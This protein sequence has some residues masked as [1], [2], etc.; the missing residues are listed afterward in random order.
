MSRLLKTLSL[1]L[2]A[3]TLGLTAQAGQFMVEYGKTKPLRLAGEAGSIVVGNPEIADVAVHDK[4][5]LFITG[6]TYGT[7]NLMVFDQHGKSVYVADVVVTTNGSNL[8]TVNRAGIDFT[9][10]CAPNCRLEGTGN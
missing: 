8:V 9:Y 5:L 3:G 2:V 6:K 7:T 1:S 4:N 10:N